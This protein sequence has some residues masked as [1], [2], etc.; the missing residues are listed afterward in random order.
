MNLT[1]DP[2]VSDDIPELTTWFPDMASVVQWGGPRLYAPLDRLQLQ[3]L[4]DAAGRDGTWRAWTVRKEGHGVVGH[5][6]LL[7]D[8]VCGQATLGRVAIAPRARGKGYAAPLVRAALEIAFGRDDI[9]RVELRVFDFN[10]AAVAVY[11]RLGFVREGT[12]REAVRVG[13]E[14]WNVHIMSL[15]RREWDAITQD[16]RVAS[17]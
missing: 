16:D 8:P 5:F 17:R 13:S 15:L 11:E 10:A 14:A 6:E 1:V 2:F 12:C 7:F 9:H 4:L 3:P